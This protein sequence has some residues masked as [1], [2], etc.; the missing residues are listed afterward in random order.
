MCVCV[1]MFVCA[2][3]CVC[4]CVCLCVWACCLQEESV[5]DAQSMR[6][7]GAIATT[8]TPTPSSNTRLD[9]PSLPVASMGGTSPGLVHR[10]NMSVL[11]SP[12]GGEFGPPSVGV[13]GGAWR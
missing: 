9:R 4:V 1:R 5:Q 7:S 11:Q 10:N 8:S 12:T 6:E 2:C 3:A 13:G